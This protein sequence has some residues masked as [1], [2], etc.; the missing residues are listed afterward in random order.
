M[1]G[2]SVRP[3]SGL[4]VTIAIQ[5]TLTDEEEA[6]TVVGVVLR[7]NLILLNKPKPPSPMDGHIYTRKS[8]T[9]KHAPAQCTHA[10]THHNLCTHTHTH[11]PLFVQ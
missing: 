9:A 11:T 5:L 2:Y 8:A 4:A 6:D 10:H 1:F 7:S 3:L